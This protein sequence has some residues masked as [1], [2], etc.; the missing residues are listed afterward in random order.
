MIFNHATEERVFESEKERNLYYKFFAGYFLNELVPGYEERVQSFYELLFNKK[1][2]KEDSFGDFKF[3][4]NIKIPLTVSVTF[5]FHG[6]LLEGAS[7]RGELA[8][9][10]IQDHQ[11]KLFIAIEAKS[12]SDWNLLK[13]VETNSN[14]IINL[15]KYAD[16]ILQVLLI[17]DAKLHGSKNKVNNH[18]SNWNKLISPERIFKVPLKII[19]WERLFDV[20][21]NDTDDS[22]RKVIEFFQ[23]H[24]K[25]KREDFRVFN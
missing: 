17:T 11:N 10:L 1:N 4:Q 6:Y 14:R 9:I 21:L 18:N 23:E 3:H 5:D 24:V 15:K 16:K 22:H 12:L 7:D 8:D 2:D 20:C 19:T 25:K 13:D